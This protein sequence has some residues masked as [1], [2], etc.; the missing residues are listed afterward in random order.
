M[1]SI[2]KLTQ[3]Q[4]NF[5][6]FLSDPD[7]A[8]EGEAVA[9]VSAQCLG[10][11]LDQVVGGFEADAEADQVRGDAGGESGRFFIAREAPRMVSLDRVSVHQ[12]P[13]REQGKRLFQ[14]YGR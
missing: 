3:C 5:F 6:I 11:V 7:T 8:A 4:Y 14:V 10:D 2:T 13:A 1:P 9:A 12:E